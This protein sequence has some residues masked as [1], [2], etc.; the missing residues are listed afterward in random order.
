MTLGEAMGY[1]TQLRQLYGVRFLGSARG[2]SSYTGKV[3]GPRRGHG[4]ARPS[5]L[6]CTSRALARASYSARSAVIGFTRS[7]RSVGTSVPAMVISDRQRDRHAKCQSVGRLHAGQQRLQRRGRRH[8][9]SRRR[10]RCRPGRATGR[11]S[12]SSPGFARLRAERHAH[13]DLLRALRHGERQ[14]AVDADAREQRTR[15]PRTRRARA[16]APCATPSRSSTTSA[17]VR[18]SEIGSFGSA[19]RMMSRIGGTSASAG[20]DAPPPG[21]SGCSR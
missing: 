18:T 10:A 6:R 2:R 12:R 13:A 21:P 14:Q 8:R 3:D 15:S 11:A 16:S 9:R 7:A 5:I 20:T 1:L 19:R 4:S 17:S